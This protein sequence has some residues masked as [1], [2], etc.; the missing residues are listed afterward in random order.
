MNNSSDPVE[1]RPL[2]AQITNTD[3]EESTT[4]FTPMYINYGKNITIGKNVFI[5]FNCTILD[6][7][8]VII[9]D[10]VLIRRILC[11]AN[12]VKP[13]NLNVFFEVSDGNMNHFCF[14]TGTMPVLDI[15]GYDNHISFF[16]VLRR[17][18]FFLIK[19]FAFSY[20]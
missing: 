8:G 7:G 17:S 6:L 2:L 16:N 10:N 5:N 11:F 1:I 3:I 15:F 14:C 13:S 4:V 18:V 20:Q 9:E 19:S 12:W